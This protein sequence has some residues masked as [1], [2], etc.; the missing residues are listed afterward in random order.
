MFFLAMRQREIVVG[1]GSS[2]PIGERGAALPRL[3]IMAWLPAAGWRA[4]AA[5]TR[6]F[7]RG[8]AVVLSGFPATA[9]IRAK[10]ARI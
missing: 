9:E 1:G 5:A 10:Q 2:P 6:D 7:D 4:E 8:V 3:L